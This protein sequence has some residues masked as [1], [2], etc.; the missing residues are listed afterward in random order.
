MTTPQSILHD[1]HYQLK[2]LTETLNGKEDDE[3]HRDIYEMCRAIE[4]ETTEFNE[5]MQ[6]L[7]D[8]MNLII[9]LLSK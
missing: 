2:A 3:E 4:I 1:L 7:E 9:K 8:K 5:R 6:L